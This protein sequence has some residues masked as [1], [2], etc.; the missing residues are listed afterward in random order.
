MQQFEKK[1]SA[2]PRNSPFI[3]TFILLFLL[4]LLRTAWISDDAAITLRTVLNFVHGFGPTFNIDERVQAYTHP[5][6]FFILSLGSLV[7]GNVFY[8]AFLISITLSTAALGLLLRNSSRNHFVLALIGLA[9]VLSKAFVDFST[10]GLE[11][12]LSHLLLLLAVLSASSIIKKGHHRLTIFF[13]ICS[14]LYLNRPDLLVMAFP[15]AVYSA[16]LAIRH[17]KQL[18][19]NLSIAAAPVI[20][21]TAFSL[22]YYGFPLPNTAYAKL[23]AGIALDER[24]IQ[25][26][27]Y[28]LHS[29]NNDPVTIFVITAGATIGFIG[30]RLSKSLSMGVMLYLI[31]II[32]IG[33]DFMEG[34]FL[35]A[36][37]F[38]SLIIFS[39]EISKKSSAI[40]LTVPVVILGS[41]SI[42]PNLIAGK[43]YSDTK[44][45]DNGIADER[46]FY[47]QNFGL[48]TAKKNTFAPPKWIV[49]DRKV[50]VICG[51]LGFSSIKLGPGMHF[52]DN[53]ALA[54]PLLAR[55][56]AKED[57]NWR[58]GHFLRQLP[59]DYKESIEKG[60]NLIVDQKTA[61]YWESIRTVTRGPLFDKNRFIEILRL[62]L[63]LTEK[64]DWVMYRTKVIPSSTFIPV[65]AESDIKVIRNEGTPWDAAGNVV[66][67]TALD[68]VLTKKIDVKSIDI[69]VDNNDIYEIA[70]LRN[71]EWIQ[72]ATISPTNKGGLARHKITLNGTFDNI[73]EIRVTGK[74]GDGRYSIGHLLVNTQ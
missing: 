59:T 65:V 67:G 64:P 34:R 15:L 32:Y 49:Y 5:L 57:P 8:T 63:D 62:N 44:I 10:S 58:I 56:P 72:L 42:Y 38:M 28:L 37:F 6:W 33:G 45:G 17:P 39:M 7:S 25:G 35:T 22:F 9:A 74:S 29:I 50:D 68:I 51:G 70:G 27:R 18:A 52:I 31:Y 26:L 14:G 19:A 4:V 61:R 73:E 69:S 54:D 3:F 53:C 11:N 40:A 48:L 12:P 47:Y 43:F 1:E 2:H 23:G 13:L 60:K 66:F 20:I 21:W 71:H 36:P 16:S 24:I 41:V 30:S 46:G 55:L